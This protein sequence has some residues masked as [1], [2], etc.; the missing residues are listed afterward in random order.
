MGTIFLRLSRVGV[1]AAVAALGLLLLPAA[2]LGAFPGG[3]GR[4][5]YDA[6]SG[7]QA[8]LFSILPDGSGLAAVTNSS[9]CE[10]QPAWSANGERIVWTHDCYGNPQI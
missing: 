5:I 2:S 1:V 7:F 10:A 8:Q 9:V 6:A 4:I 3:N